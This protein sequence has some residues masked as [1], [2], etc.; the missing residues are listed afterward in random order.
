MDAHVAA[1]MALGMAVAVAMTVQTPAPTGLPDIGAFVARYDI[2]TNNEAALY[3]FT[4][5]GQGMIPLSDEQQP[6]IVVEPMRRSW[7]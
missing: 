4:P 2:S 3:Y 1:L 5:A 6:M 7:D